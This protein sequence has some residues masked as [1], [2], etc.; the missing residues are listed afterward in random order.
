MDFIVDLIIHVWQITSALY[1]KKNQE[2]CMKERIGVSCRW[3]ADFSKF[4]CQVE[5]LPQFFPNI[6]DLPVV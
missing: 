6:P 3:Q 5:M 2:N 1:K 4:N